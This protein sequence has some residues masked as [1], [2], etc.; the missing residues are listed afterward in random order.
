V[1]K[2]VKKL[3]VTNF[4]IA[5]AL[6]WALK[7]ILVGNNI[8]GTEGY[9]SPVKLAAKSLLFL[10]NDV[11]GAALFA[12]LVL[13]FCLPLIY[14]SLDRGA[15]A[16]S[17]VLQTVHGFFV[18]VSSFTAIFVGACID[19]AALDVAFL[20]QPLTAGG[21]T[22]LAS[23]ID[24]YLGFWSLSALLIG[25]VG[26]PLAL[27]FVPG[28]LARVARRLRLVAAGVLG[29]LLVLTTCLLPFL[30]NGELWGIRVHTYG[31]EKSA[32]LELGASYVKPILRQRRLAGRKIEDPFILD[33]TS[34]TEPDKKLDNLLE[35]AQPKRTNVVFISLES[36]SAQYLEVPDEEPLMPYLSGIA[37]K[38]GAVSMEWHFTT[39]AQT[40]K[41]FFT[42]F[43]SEL[44]HP[45]YPS[46]CHTNPAIPCK[47]LSEA[48][49]DDGYFTA[50]VTSADLA[51]DRKMRFF[52]H[53][54]FDLVWDMRNM[55][56][57]EGV[58]KDSWGHDERHTVK[59]L[60]ELADEHRDERFFIFYEMATAH[61]PYNACQ[62]HID[63]PIADEWLSYRRA[64]GFVD[65][66]VRGVVEGLDELG[67]L[68]DTLVFIASDHGEGFGQ[69]PGSK[70][71]GPKVYNENVR[72]PCVFKGP[73]LAELSGR[74]EFPTSHLDLA[75]TVLGLLGIPVPCT[76]KGRNLVE[77]APNRVMLIGGRPPGGQFGLVDGRWKYI[78]EDSGMEML[79]DL[80]L[81]PDESENVIDDHLEQAAA[82]REK[83]LDWH[84]FSENLIENYGKILGETT[85]RP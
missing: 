81:D 2:K 36:V 20:E 34:P 43:C 38:P 80:A 22:A 10:G 9:A 75:P 49:H 40:M 73:Q 44:P 30:I 79:F 23:S 66:R 28:L 26:P 6:L 76:M 71:H 56:G 39:W 7:L 67:L 62:A 59:K 54:A 72:V 41:V 3:W 61:H 82:Y 60:L 65:D 31:L 57:R 70:S 83:L 63:E 19:K 29:I 74:V 12:G 11:L 25:T 8:F 64:L 48:L 42:E 69:H 17:A 35:S 18:T 33:L 68:D 58:W 21:G 77:G 84:V 5:L 45:D 27:F 78:M 51:Y 46:I 1:W 52:R 55:P 13:L 15:L 37:A 14:W 53:R 85:C 32:F 24:V 16:I 47:S 4:V 50:L